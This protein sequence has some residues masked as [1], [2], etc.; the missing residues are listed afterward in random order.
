MTQ[1]EL[2]VLSMVLGPGRCPEGVGDHF[3]C[4]TWAPPGLLSPFQNRVLI[5]YLDIM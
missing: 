3:W 5:S 1:Y 2:T 4:L